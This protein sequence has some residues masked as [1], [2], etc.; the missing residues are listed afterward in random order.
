MKKKIFFFELKVTD[1]EKTELGK[2]IMVKIGEVDYK[3]VRMLTH[4][5]VNSDEIDLALTKI[6]YV[7]REY[8]RD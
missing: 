1:L 7:S 6:E 5:D 3:T 2:S 4:L 8:Q